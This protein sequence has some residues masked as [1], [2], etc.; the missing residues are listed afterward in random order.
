MA[1]K[2]R[3]I[4]RP[5]GLSRDNSILLLAM[6]LAGGAIGC[7]QYILPLYAAALG[8]NPDQVGLTL[9]I[10]NSGAIVGI[11]AGGLFV[12]RFSYRGQIW[13]S[14]LLVIPAY[15]LY[16]FAQSWEAVALGTF[17]EWATLFCIPALN[18]YI[19]LAC[20]DESP[21]QAFTIVYA[22]ITAGTAV[23]PVIGGILAAT[24]GLRAP[25]VAAVVLEGLSL[26]CIF[27]I[28]ERQPR[29][30]ADTVNEKGGSFLARLVRP[31]QDYRAALD[32]R[33]FRNL[34]LI[35]S[36][37]YVSSF[38]GVSLQ[39]NYL[40]DRGGIDASLISVFGSAASAFSVVASVALGRWSSAL[41][42]NRIVALTQA[43]ILIGLILTVLAPSLGPWLL[44]VSGIGFAL[45]GGT[46]AQQS[47]T[48]GSIATVVSETSA[49]PAYAFQ[50]LLFWIA[51]V[52]GAAVAGVAYAVGPELPVVI[53]VIVGLPTIL[54]MGTRGESVRSVTA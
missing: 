40:H 43:L 46:N 38:I 39:P 7:Y 13:V 5:L 50:S 51:Q 22:G 1:T 49:G 34:M 44:V 41:G 2:P 33:A 16:V 9:A 23:T 15:I 11:A 47:L 30:S 10:G 17:L 54:L 42:I 32:N 29:R 36:V 21:G 26:G 27:L 18:A 35:L 28:R 8:A 53:A 14:W 24:W 6:L 48:R 31:F 12:N 45:R 52:V 20:E 4:L 25:F 3:S 19:V 37:I